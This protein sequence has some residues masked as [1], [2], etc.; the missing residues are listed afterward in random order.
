MAIHPKIN[1]TKTPTN[2]I[3]FNE[4]S[5]SIIAA[6]TIRGIAIINENLIASSLLTPRISRIE[7]VIPD[8]DTPGN[9]ANI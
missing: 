3:M 2:E 8:L 7:I 1:D 6:P 9:N 4:K 5:P